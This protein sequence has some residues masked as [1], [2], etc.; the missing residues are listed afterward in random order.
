MNFLSRMLKYSFLLGT[1]YIGVST[2][3]A[4]IGDARLMSITAFEKTQQGLLS[5]WTFESIGPTIFSGRVVDIAV[6]PS[7]PTHYY[8]AYASGGLWVTRNN[9]TTFSPIFDKEAVMTIG[10]I[11]VNWGNGE[12]WVGTGEVNSSRSSYA[13]VG[14]FLSQDNGAT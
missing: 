14:V 1:L 12:I 2:L 8:V 6:N 4:Q 7:D 10:A 3:F 11:A 13:G 9:G 5:Q